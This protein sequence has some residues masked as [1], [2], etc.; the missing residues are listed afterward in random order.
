MQLT[1]RSAIVTG[2]GQGGGYGAAL[3]LAR[4]GAG[5]L[6]MGRTREKLEGVADEIQGFG[7]TAMVHAGDVTVRAD[8]EAAI[9]AALSRFGK[10]DILVNAAQSPEDRNSPL[11]ETDPAVME[12]MWQSGFVATLEF[13]RACQPHMREAGGGAIINFSSSSLTVAR[14]H[15]VYGGVKAAVQIMSRA[16]ALEWAPD[17][18]RVNVVFPLVA[19]P[20]YYTFV[21][22]HPDHA[23]AFEAGIP[24]GRIGDPE[25]DIGRAIVFL[26][27]DDSGY[28][29]GATLPLDGGHVFIR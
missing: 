28:M 9:A 10:I 29:T 5:V 18:I 21:K 16:A 17:K 27:S 7:G 19:S 11:L 26:A 3:A 6:L 8:R 12:D 14:N 25:R 23:T 22:N 24:L 2:A 20:A 13:M 15:G 4:A 1:G